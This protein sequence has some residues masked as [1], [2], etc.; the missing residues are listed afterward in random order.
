M[1]KYVAWWPV[2]DSCPGGI[3]ERDDP[4]AGP[5][6]YG[7]L[8]YSSCMSYTGVCPFLNGEPGAAI[9][10]V[11]PFS[12]PFCKRKNRSQDGLLFVLIIGPLWLPRGP[13][14]S[15]D[16]PFL[17]DRGRGGNEPAEEDRRGREAAV[18]A[19]LRALCIGGP[20]CN[21]VSTGRQFVKIIENNCKTE[22]TAIREGGWTPGRM[23]GS[24][25]AKGRKA[26]CFR[27]QRR[28]SSRPALR[29]R[30]LRFFTHLPARHLQPDFWLRRL[31]P[32]L[33]GYSEM[34]GDYDGIRTFRLIAAGRNFTDALK[35]GA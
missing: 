30:V 35:G 33:P 1:L 9:G 7:D 18:E 5:P 13:S 11:P 14:R 8:H 20:A 6:G 10:P 3:S 29:W 23:G 28:L 19:L 22:N 24:S 15:F 12:C 17:R 25:D 32:G 26:G 21:I 31:Q 27:Q 34:G 16:L 2:W 4:P